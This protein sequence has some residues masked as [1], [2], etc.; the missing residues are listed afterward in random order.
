MAYSFNGKPQASILK[1]ATAYGLPL[2]EEC[3]SARLTRLSF[4]FA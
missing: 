4:P 1:F 2:N 3:L